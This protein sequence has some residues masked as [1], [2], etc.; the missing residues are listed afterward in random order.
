M[1]PVEVEVVPPAGAD[2]PAGAAKTLHFE[3]LDNRQLTPSAMLVSVY[4]SL[5]TNN[6]AAE[7]MSYRLTGELGR[8]GAA[9]GADAGDDG[10]E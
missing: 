4:Q 1:I 5:Q 3:V 8:E 2:K 7:E 10:A 9:A 6:T